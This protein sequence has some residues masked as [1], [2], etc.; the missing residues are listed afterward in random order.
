MRFCNTFIQA[1]RRKVGRPKERWQ[2]NLS[3]L[4]RREGTGQ[5]SWWYWWW[6]WRWLYNDVQ[7][8]CNT[9]DMQH[10]SKLGFG[11]RVN[12]SPWKVPCFE[13]YASG[14]C[15]L[16][17]F[18]IS[19]VKSLGPVA[20]IIIFLITLGHKFSCKDVFRMYSAP[21]SCSEVFR[22]FFS[23]LRHVI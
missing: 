2:S 12:T 18:G 7:T 1:G 9:E 13:M 10:S 3:S 19:S 22:I 14:P 8:C 11:R 6:W 5:M 17:D 16:T 23:L 21:Y 4:K 15:P 20:T